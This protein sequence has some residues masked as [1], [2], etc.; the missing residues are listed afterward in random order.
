MLHV[1]VPIVVL[2]IVFILIAVRQVGNI[3]FQLWQIMLL[4][5]I[6]VLL[7]GSIPPA[8]ALKAIDLDVLLFL[9]GMF[10]IGVALEESG[11]IS[12]LS[13]ML[14]KNARS[15]DT[16]VLKILFFMGF[17]S[18]FLM[19][20]TLAIIG[21]PLMLLL[22]KKHNIN[23]KVLLL[24]L[25]FAITTGSVMS[26][27][28]NPQ[29]LLIS[30]NG[31]LSNP[32]I[33]FLKY[34]FLPTMI[35]IFAAYLILR[36]LYRDEFHRN[37]LRHVYEPIK[38]KK[39]AILSKYSLIVVVVLAG[40]TIIISLLHP[41]FDFNLTYIALIGSL[42]ILLF[43]NKRFEIIKNVDWRTLIFFAAMFVLMKSVWL[44]GFFQSSVGETPGSIVSI[45]S[46]LEIS[47][48]LS[49]L[50]SNVPMVALYLPVLMHAGASSTALIALAAGSTIAGNLLILGAASN[51][52]IIQ[53]AEKKSRETLTFLEFAKAG[54]PLTII[55]AAVYWFFL[56]V[57]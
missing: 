20:D 36:M 35:N 33:T 29:N 39:L 56:K 14:F 31:N 13:Y 6:A 57:V 46:V 28:G 49:Q 48:I 42:P 23:P 9:F 25:A 51:I 12:H 26:P 38:D 22:A 17:T 2:A 5:A 52:I 15:V 8:T 34:L 54:I 45:H 40:L 44:T 27:I 53:N 18:A 1:S 4:G 55:N 41:E 50:I 3:R 7:T 21:T 10:V 30:I 43:S 19:N 47:V 32:F 37:R 24:T 16:L 11:Y